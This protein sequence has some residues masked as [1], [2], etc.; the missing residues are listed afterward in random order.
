LLEK[1]VKY[2]DTFIIT[3]AAKGWVEY[4]SQLLMPQTHALLESKNIKIISARS[5][6]EKKFPG[7]TKRWKRE[8]F[9]EISKKYVYSVEPADPGHHEHRV[10]RRFEHRNG[11]CEAVRGV[12]PPLPVYSASNLASRP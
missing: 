1:S 7:E 4:S 2:G 9:V 8:A 12:I 11:G 5:D 3:N 10:S 6:F